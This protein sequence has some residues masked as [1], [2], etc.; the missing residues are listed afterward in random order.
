MS[1]TFIKTICMGNNNKINKNDKLN[2]SSV[3]FN[4]FNKKSKKKQLE[5]K[6]IQ[7][8]LRIERAIKEAEQ[9]CLDK[10]KTTDECIIAWDKVEDLSKAAADYNKFQTCNIFDLEPSENIDFDI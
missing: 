7:D 9:I 5:D 2:K 10:N 8:R 4:L 1:L 6:L 3:R